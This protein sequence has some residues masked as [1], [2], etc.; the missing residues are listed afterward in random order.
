MAN[1]TPRH[2]TYYEG[3]DDGSVLEALA[4]GGLLPP[5]LEVV[6]RDNRRKNPGKDGM[7]KDIA[8]L[9][10]PAG[11]AGRSAVAIRDVDELSAAQVAD[12]FI[13][14]M[15]AELPKTAPPVQVVAQAGTAKALYFRVEA[16]G[17]PH[18]GRV[19]LVPVGLPSG[20]AATE[21][22]ITQFAVDDYILLLAR[23]K[24][25]YD[26]ISEFKE[27]S[28]DLALKK[29]AEAVGLM[30]RNSIPIK[31]TKRLMHLFRAVT[32]FRASPATFA[33]RLV[34][35]GSAILGPARIR[36]LF[37]PLIESLEEASKL[38]TP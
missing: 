4:A 24:T 20:V 1:G 21:Y 23:D 38:L 37:L 34:R 18:A 3:D 30:K 26:S 36:D 19:V 14:R 10:N 35:Q 11:G 7:V 12:W 33:D 22:E 13:D 25:V 29:L 15:N 31:H 27:V 16:P 17:A 28:Q 6:Q 8:A 32:G 9:V 5:D 2:R